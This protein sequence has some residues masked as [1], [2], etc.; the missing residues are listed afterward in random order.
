MDGIQIIPSRVACESNEREWFAE[1]Y[2][3]WR[4]GHAKRMSK[5]YRDKLIEVFRS[6]YAI[7]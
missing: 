1:N 2:A 6:K 7:R 4:T 5:A 3:L